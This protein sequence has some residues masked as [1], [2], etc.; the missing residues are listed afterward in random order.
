[1]LPEDLGQNQNF[2]WMSPGW[3][4]RPPKRLDRPPQTEWEKQE[5]W[6]NPQL[7]ITRSPHSPNGLQRNF[8][9]AWVTSWT[10]SLSKELHQNALNHGESQI[11]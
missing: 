9:D 2:L 4:D 5:Q 11:S 6:V 10:T 7:C 3:L 8:G 1:M